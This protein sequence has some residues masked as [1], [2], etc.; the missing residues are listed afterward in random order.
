MFKTKRQRQQEKRLRENVD[1]AKKRKKDLRAKTKIVKAPVKPILKPKKKNGVFASLLSRLFGSK[2]I[3]QT[4]QQSIPY[5]TIYKD[6]V[7][8]VKDNHYTKTIA[9][10]DINYQLCA[11]RSHTNTISRGIKLCVRSDHVVVKMG[12]FL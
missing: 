10:G 7:C 2:T 12:G 8:R 4:A 5:H 9:F 6:G 11:T 1:E 3:P